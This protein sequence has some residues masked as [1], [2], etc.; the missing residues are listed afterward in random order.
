[1]FLM[2]SHYEYIFAFGAPA[3]VT[4]Y[5]WILDVPSG[6]LKRLKNAK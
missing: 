3:S 5:G 2:H 6:I 4:S 1:M